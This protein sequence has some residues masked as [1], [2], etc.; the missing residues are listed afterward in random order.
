MISSGYSPT[1][2]IGDL[3]VRPGLYS[4]NG[5]MAVPGG[6][7]FTV[8][9]NGATSATLVLYHR[10]AE[11]PFAV[12]PFPDNYRIGYTYSIIVFGIDVEEVE[13][14]YRLDG[15]YD[16]SKGLLFDKK[17]DLLDP[18]AMAVVGQS[19]WGEDNLNNGGYRARIVYDDYDWKDSRFPRIPM[20]DSIIYEM[21]VRGFTMN[22]SSGVQYPGTFAGLIEKIPYLKELGVTAVELMP[23]ME[24]DE[25]INS[26]DY[27]GRK[28]YEYWG[29]NTVS[30]FAPNTSYAASHEFNY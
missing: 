19:H 25:T 9:S 27:N 8:H 21:H 29:Y 7:N 13:Y 11:K 4:I 3:W 12:I 20:Q 17:N 18:Y 22:R 26:R 15:P 6:A 2:K 16:P 14:T 23:I 5:T 28:L 1:M 30:F 10:K 24:F